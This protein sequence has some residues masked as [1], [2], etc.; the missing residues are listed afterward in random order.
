MNQDISMGKRECNWNGIVAA[1]FYGTCSASMAFANK[2]IMSSYNFDF[3]FLILVLQ[4][5]FSIALVELLMIC[6]WTKLPPYSVERGRLFLFPSICAALHSSLSLMALKG[7][8][9]P[10]YGAL[11]RC[12][13]MVNLILSVL[14]L[15]KPFPSCLIISSIMLITLGCLVAG[16]GDL[17]FDGVA[18]VIGSLSVVVQGLY[19][20]LIQKASEKN[21]S[22]FEIFQLNCY[23]CLP[24]FAVGSIL[25]TEPLTV[26]NFKNIGDTDFICCLLLVVILGSILNYSLFLS[27]SLNSALTTS[28]I[29][30]LKSVLQTVIGFFT[31]GG[32]AYNPINMAGIV[33]NS[34]GGAFY[35][36]AKLKENG[37]KVS[38]TTKSLTFTNGGR[39]QK[40]HNGIT[41]AV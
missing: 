35:T 20:T 6:G 4:M 10:M 21:L 17:S 24:M 9:I 7:M 2:A 23:N 27:T 16:I 37:K 19:Q 33:L 36:Y 38:S 11:K 39:D 26:T 40:L 12:T 18:Y 8:N 13:P 34:L 3:P 30:V 5:L 14:I 31:F 41:Q 28:L 25:T 29:G 1:V 32:V 22:V 15:H